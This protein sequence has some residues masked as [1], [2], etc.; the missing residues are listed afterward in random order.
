MLKIAFEISDGATEV[1]ERPVLAPLTADA[2]REAVNDASVAVF[3]SSEEASNVKSC[4]SDVTEIEDAELDARDTPKT[5]DRFPYLVLDEL[6]IRVWKI[7]NADVVA[8]AE[9]SD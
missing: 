8:V 6:S 9:L 5:I 7:S 4:V 1:S 3:E 2:I